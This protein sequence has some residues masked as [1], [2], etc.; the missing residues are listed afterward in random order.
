MRVF[1]T[2]ASGW[3]GAAVVDELLAAGHA[4]LGLARSDSAAAAIAARG[5]AVQRG[6]LDD[7]AVLQQAAAQCDAVVHTGFLHDFS[8]FA[9]CC[10]LDRRAIAALGEALRGT[11]R[12]LLVTSGMATAAEGRVATEEDAPRLSSPTYPRA[13]EETAR[14]LAA[15]GV[16]AATVR[17][18]PSVHG[19]GDYGF[20]PHL[21]ALAREKGVSAY[22]G[23]GN[24][25]WPAVHRFD[26]ARV[27]R[28]AL[29]RGTPAAT[30]HAVADEG[31]AFREIAEA[32][33]HGLKLPA[34]S[35]THPQAA[36][37]FG[38]FLP[39]ASFDVPASSQRTREWL[40]WQPRECSLTADLFKAH[41]FSAAR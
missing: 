33:A 39:F 20:V 10:E 8:R 5:A 25:R 27:Y 18:P 14:Q 17:L 4:V 19:E 29:E 21:I 3:V 1:V 6:T 28:L 23:G 9:E 22:I 7:L 36:D 35:L 40:G 15:D 24:N 31:I 26:A 11:A 30:L 12:P 16:C 34:V 32:I 2:G 37:H 41:Y 38:W 13:S